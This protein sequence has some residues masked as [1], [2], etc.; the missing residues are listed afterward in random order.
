MFG[1]SILF[2]GIALD[3]NVPATDLSVSFSSDKDGDL[4]SAT[5]DS[6]GSVTFGTDSLSNNMHVI[7]LVVTDEVGASC[8]S[9]L[10]L[11]GA[12]QHKHLHASTCQS[13]Q[14]LVRIPSEG[15]PPL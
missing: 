2:E 4:G 6:N 1:T 12:L 15:G 11:L 5:I 7:S 9:S 3:D 13:K 10:V 8:Q 14:K